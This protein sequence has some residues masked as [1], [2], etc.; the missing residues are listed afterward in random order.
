MSLI[1]G[2]ILIMR[3]MLG[4]ERHITANCLQTDTRIRGTPRA[5][6][7]FLDSLYLTLLGW[8]SMTFFSVDKH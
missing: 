7:D 8:T 2:Y 5:D 3:F 1:K 4:K 6:P